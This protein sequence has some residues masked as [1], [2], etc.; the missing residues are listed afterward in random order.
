MPNARIYIAA[1]I[2]VFI[3]VLFL[4]PN[5]SSKETFSSYD[6]EL[7]LYL[8]MTPEDK[9]RYEL[10]SRDQKVSMYGNKI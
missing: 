1:I 6:R 4:I 9:K 8:S 7:K 5:K 3:V 10:M 2:A